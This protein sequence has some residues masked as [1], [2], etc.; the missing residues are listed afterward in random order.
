[1]VKMTLG[2]SQKQL[3]TEAHIA[4]TAR[5]VTS[6]PFSNGLDLFLQEKQA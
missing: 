1:M 3:P 2:R 6:F 5:E 4:T